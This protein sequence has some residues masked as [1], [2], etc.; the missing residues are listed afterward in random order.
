L[1]RLS[2]RLPFERLPRAEAL[3]FYEAQIVKADRAKKLA[4]RFRSFWPRSNKTRL[5]KLDFGIDKRNLIDG[6]PPGG[7]PN[8]KRA[9]PNQK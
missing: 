3:G 7:S 8:A 5:S 9:F 4:L 1:R 6:S 2:G